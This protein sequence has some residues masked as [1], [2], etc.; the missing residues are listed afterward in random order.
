MKY[1]MFK[2]HI[3]V[4]ESLKNLK[5]VLKSGFLN[6]GEEVEKF[7]N[8]L[9][10]YFN[11]DNVIP[12]NSC[13][14]ALT[15]ALKLSGV[16]HGD[17]VVTTSMTCVAT[18]T[19]ILN[20][21]ANVVWADIDSRTGNIS[22]ES[23]ANSITSKTKAVICVNWAGNPCD[24]IKLQKICND[25]N[26]K[27]IQDAAHSFGSK[28]KGKHVCHVADFTCYSFQAIKHVTCGDGGALVCNNEEDFYRGKKLKWFGLD[29]EATKN[30]KGEWKGQRWEVD[31]IEAGYKFHMNNIS[32]AIGNSQIRHYDRIVDLHKTNARIYDS[33]IEGNKLITPIKV[34][35]E[36][37]SSHWV[38]TAILHESVKRDSVL[39][40]LNMQGINAGLVHIP[41]HNYT[42]FNASFK[43]LPETEYFAKHQISIPC[44]WW[45]NSK[46]SN[47]IIDNVINSVNKNRG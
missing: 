23:V 20:L 12:L 44:G 26:I 3:D 21:G 38:Y 45:I 39:E 24:L 30:E 14:S 25:K 9:I 42:C 15:L 7:K 46:D 13:T 2:V 4:N 35:P 1:P 31:I 6:E 18:N 41:N 40:H 32:A 36:A 33:A 16:S 19:P 10:E 34:L 27:L 28:F 5:K 29:R 37:K 43:T 22:P 17:D 8:S 11:H 47:F